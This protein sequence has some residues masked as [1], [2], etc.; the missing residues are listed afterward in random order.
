[1]RPPA[2]V[3]SGGQGAGWRARVPR[4][5]AEIVELFSRNACVLSRQAR[6]SRCPLPVRVQ[7]SG[8]SCLRLGRLGSFEPWLRHPRRLRV[9]QV[10]SL[11][12]SPSM[13]PPSSVGICRA[14]NKW[15]KPV[16]VPDRTQSR[17]T[18]G[19]P[20]G[21]FR[22][23]AGRAIGWRCGSASTERSDH[24]TIE[25]SRLW[26]S[27]AIRP[28]SSSPSKRLCSSD[29]AASY[30]PLPSSVVRTRSIRFLILASSS[31]PV[32]SAD[33]PGEVREN[34]GRLFGGWQLCRGH[35]RNK[36]ALLRKFSLPGGS[37]R[38][39]GVN[40]AARPRRSSKRATVIGCHLPP[41]TVSTPL[42]LRTAAIFLVDRYLIG[43]T[44]SRNA[45]AC[46]GQPPA[47]RKTSQ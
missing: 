26:Y 6:K 46:R 10:V 41:R 16:P 30:S 2:P 32:L 34:R 42:P 5:A 8:C 27:S 17:L 25:L 18:G 7:W 36:N 37:S 20:A 1:M 4:Y 39:H 45:S 19:H 21:R 11:R 35:C 23:G 14:K 40:H 38:N 13:T 44:I 31:L 12:P 22:D 33:D 24:S 3:Q 9:D 47:D 29:T 28:A 15:Q 43:S